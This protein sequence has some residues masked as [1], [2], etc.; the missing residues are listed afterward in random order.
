M[1]GFAVVVYLPFLFQG[2]MAEWGGLWT[3]GQRF[4]YNSTGY[5]LLTLVLSEESARMVG[6]GL[7]LVFAGLAWQNWRQGNRELWPPVAAILAVAFWWS[8]V[9]NPWYAL[10]ILPSVALRPSGWG[11]GVL[12]AVPLA[13]THG[14]GQS[15][16]AVVSYL[17]PWWTRPLE[18]LV[19]LLA[20]TSWWGWR[21]W[22][23][24]RVC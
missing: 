5:A 11:I 14:W 16:G 10:W 8:P 23:G 1:V 20:A 18:V 19:V 12:I 22:R 21:N 2:S 4:E 6:A 9:F 13:Y 7:T 17:H 15:G 3:M 24:Q